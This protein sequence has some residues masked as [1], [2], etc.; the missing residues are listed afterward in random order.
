ARAAP[1]HPIYHQHHVLSGFAIMKSIHHW[2]LP[3]IVRLGGYKPNLEA[4]RPQVKAARDNNFQG[5]TNRMNRKFQA[6]LFALTRVA[7]ALAYGQTAAKA[8]APTPASKPATRSEEHTSELQ[9]RENLV[10]R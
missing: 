3:F 10:C 5:I 2:I 6:R 8:A 9:S 4:R 1:D 7:S